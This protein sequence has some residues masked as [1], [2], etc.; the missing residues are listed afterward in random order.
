MRDLCSSDWATDIL[1]ESK[2]YIKNYECNIL[3]TMKFLCELAQMDGQVEKLTYID[4]HREDACLA[5]TMAETFFTYQVQKQYSA[6]AELLLR[7]QTLTA[8][9]REEKILAVIT[10]YGLGE[11]RVGKVN[12]YLVVRA[13]MKVIPISML[14]E[15]E[16]KLKAML[17]GK[18]Y[19]DLTAEVLE[20][21]KN[22]LRREWFVNNKEEAQ[23][24]EEAKNDDD[25]KEV[26]SNSEQKEETLSYEKFFS[27]ASD[28][29]YYEGNV[30]AESLRRIVRTIT[31]EEWK[32]L[33]K[34]EE[35]NSI[36]WIVLAAP[37]ER[38]KLLYY[39]EENERDEVA[40]S[41]LDESRV[42]ELDRAVEL[43]III[44]MKLYNKMKYGFTYFD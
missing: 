43:K 1:I 5:A 36:T 21:Y 44:F 17:D 19:E 3:K 35:E 6:E 10:A 42:I 11:L 25:E 37:K 24:S 34:A 27:E 12:V 22:T 41:C 4:E 9:E 28:K 2:E 29:I 38:K 40:E 20:N 26:E 31:C 39:Y 15:F 33:V 8:N 14:V 13:M 18:K 23:E 32:K 7:Y 16:M 30:L